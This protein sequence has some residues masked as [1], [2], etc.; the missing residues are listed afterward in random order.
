MICFA[1]FLCSSEFALVQAAPANFRAA[2]YE[3]RA[4]SGFLASLGMTILERDASLLARA[5]GFLLCC[6]GDDPQDFFFTH[7]DEVFA[8]EL[9]LRAAVLAEEDSVAFFYVEGADLAFFV[10]FAFAGG[11]DFALLGLVLCRVRDDDATAGGFGLFHTTNQNAVVQGSELGSH[12]GAA[13]FVVKFVV[14]VLL[15]LETNEC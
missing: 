1:I 4:N 8:V 13:P 6:A 12:D 15:A 2:S 11:D 5:G 3:L 14:G 10:D 7:D 9:D